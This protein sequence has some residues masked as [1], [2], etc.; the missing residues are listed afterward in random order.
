M[1]R[2]LDDNL[3]ADLVGAAIR[4]AAAAGPDGPAHTVVRRVAVRLAANA[5][6]GADPVL[7]G[8]GPRRTPDGVCTLLPGL[9]ATD[10]VAGAAA[11]TA[12]AITVSQ[13]DEGLREARGHPGL[14]A[15]AA[16]LPIAEAADRSLDDLLRALAT[17]W[18]VGARLGLVLGPPR[19]GVHP[20]GGWG[21]AAAATAAGVV[22]GLPAPALVDA[23][24]AA[25]TVG[26]AGPD[27]TTWQGRNS[28]FLLPGLG[29]A[30]GLTV[31]Y[32]VRDGLQPPTAALPHFARIAHTGESPAAEVS[33]APVD[34][35]LT[36]RPLL[37]E[38]YFKP[39]GF[40]AHTLTSWTAARELSDSIG[41]ADVAE[42]TVHTYAA[43]AALADRRPAN[44]LARQFSIPWAV[45]CGLAGDAGPGASE[46]ELNWLA[47][48]VEVRHDPQLDQGYPAG[49]PAT[50]QVRTGD[51]RTLVASA[52]YHPGDRE[53]PLDAEQL[54]AVNA[55]LLAASGVPARAPEL[56]RGLAAA[57][58]DTPVRRLTACL[59]VP[60]VLP[61]ASS[62]RK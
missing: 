39:I 54:D 44:R 24:R 17:G 52:R 10:D 56:L 38:A 9:G 57:S 28:H 4:A 29:T 23:V 1:T 37:L 7:S 33:A 41:A 5:M 58:T 40:C 47:E 14:H 20:H 18:E 45:A 51:G 35:A 13:C 22:L 62:G 30:N 48:R 61:P 16:A 21:A 36:D 11:V 3:L 26:L 2:R 32:L 12:A 42:V 6:A 27:D 53:T 50:V 49:R 25:L 8:F 19:P 59:R 43:A 31:A 34:V 55:Q 46:S 15:F 60:G